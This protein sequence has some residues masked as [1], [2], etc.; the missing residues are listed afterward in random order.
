MALPEH[1]LQLLSDKVKWSGS[2]SSKVLRNLR[3]VIMID[4]GRTYTYMGAARR[5]PRSESAY[6]SPSVLLRQKLGI[7]R[8]AVLHAALTKTTGSE[9]L[10]G[11]LVL[12]NSNTVIHSAVLKF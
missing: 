9:I 1:S 8:N 4:Q 2:T 10:P 11:L 6:Y 12:Y 7:K 5:N 3:A